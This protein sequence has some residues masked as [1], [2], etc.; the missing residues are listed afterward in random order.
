L[1][2]QWMR[3]GKGSEM[4]RK[5]NEAWRL[6][7]LAITVTKASGWW[8]ELDGAYVQAYADNRLR[9]VYSPPIAGS[10]MPYQLDIWK[11]G[12]GRPV[13][14]LACLWGA[15]GAMVVEYRA[16]VWE[17]SLRAAC[18]VLVSGGGQVEGPLPVA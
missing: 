8:T 17:R 15:S 3:H 10:D 6:R 12:E 11:I 13:K 4:S 5:E 18:G 1:I 14:V 7:D 9:I 16:G 2:E